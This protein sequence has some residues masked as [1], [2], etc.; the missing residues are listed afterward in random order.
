MAALDLS[1]FTSGLQGIYIVA[2]TLM[3]G[4]ILFFGGW[5]V[6]RELQFK[7]KV[8]VHKVLS[9]GSITELYDRARHLRK[10]EKND[11][12]L[13]RLREII[14]KPPIDY[15]VKTM[16]GERY[17]FRWDGG[18]VFVPQKLAYNS[19]LE[20]HP[21]QYNINTQMAWRIR[22]RAERHGKKNIWLE[23]APFIAWFLVIILVS[24]TLW[25]LFSKLDVVAGSIDNLARS[26]ADWGKQTIS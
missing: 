16:R 17:Y 3:S 6:W 9:D 22:N 14:T 4:A 11:I 23:Y 13:K 5:W 21:G 10:G 15:A 19:P 8:T 20:F 2:I 12:Q 26:V 1:I 18:H 25:Q 24:I 7:H